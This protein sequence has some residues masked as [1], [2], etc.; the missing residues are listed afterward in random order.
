MPSAMTMSEA[1]AIAMA[2]RR[3]VV[4]GLTIERSN[5]VKQDK[6]AIAKRALAKGQSQCYGYEKSPSRSD[7]AV[8]EKVGAIAHRAAMRQSPLRSDKRLRL[9]EKR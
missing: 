8:R 6:I 1:A 5:E 7:E 2:E 4:G 3:T 9:A